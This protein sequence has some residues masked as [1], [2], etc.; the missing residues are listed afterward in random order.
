MAKNVAAIRDLYP[1]LADR[2]ASWPGGWFDPAAKKAGDVYVSVIVH[3]P[4]LAKAYR[5]SLH[6]RH[7][8]EAGYTVES[9]QPEGGTRTY[10]L[11][12]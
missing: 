9:F 10:R 12:E 11:S 8:E 7:Y 5:A 1:V 2:M 6:R 4:G 3:V